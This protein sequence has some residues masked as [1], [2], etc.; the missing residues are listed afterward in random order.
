MAASIMRA[1]DRRVGEV[2]RRSPT[3][4]RWMAARRDLELFLAGL[5]PEERE[6]LADALADDVDLDALTEPQRDLAAE[7]VQLALHVAYERQWL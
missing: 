1:L 2:E 6:G 4:E 5:W 7:T 3:Y